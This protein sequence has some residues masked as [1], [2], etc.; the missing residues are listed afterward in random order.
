MTG[1]RHWHRNLRNR[2][3]KN[4]FI[5]LREYRYKLTKQQY[6][7]FKGQIL[8]GDIEGFRKGLFIPKIQKTLWDKMRSDSK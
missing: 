4:C 2:T 6:K 3:I 7:T 1:F 8:K 5:L